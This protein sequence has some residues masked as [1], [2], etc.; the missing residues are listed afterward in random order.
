MELKVKKSFLS[1]IS[2]MIQPKVLLK[3]W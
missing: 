1:L 2:E 3:R